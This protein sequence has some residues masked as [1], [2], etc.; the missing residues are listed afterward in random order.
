MDYQ[1]E[2]DRAMARFDQFA[3]RA[4]QRQLGKWTQSR[5]KTGTARLARKLTHGGIAIAAILAVMIVVGL[6]VDGIGL[7]GL[8]IAAALMLAAILFI[9]FRPE[10]AVKPVPAFSEDMSNKAVVQRLGTFLGRHRGHLPA[11]AG[12]RISAIQ[13]QLPML[14]AQLADMPLLDPLAQDARRLAG[15][16]LPE[17]IERYERVPPQYRRERERDG[18]SVDDRLV[19][20]LDAAKVAIDDLGRRMSRQEMDEFETQGRF[21]ESRYQDPDLRS[22][23]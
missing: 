20:G 13:A 6:V 12:Q 10:P 7:T 18:L 3:D 11:A 1:S 17:L 4:D 5:A 19:A 8:F 2:M 14:E 22:D 21:L 16:H 9:G 23:G 15:Q